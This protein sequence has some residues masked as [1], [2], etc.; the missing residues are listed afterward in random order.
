MSGVRRFSRPSVANLL[1]A[2]VLVGFAA[3]TAAAGSLTPPVAS[4][5]PH[6]ETLHGDAITDD[7]F[8]LRE[9]TNPEVL[10]YLEAEN[11]YAAQ[12]LAPL[13]GLQESLY[14]EMLGRIQQTDLSVPYRQGGAWYYTR[15]EEGKQYPIYCRKKGTLDGKEQVLLDVNELAKGRRYTAVSMVEPSDDGKRIAVAVD[16]TGYRQ[17]WLFV[18]NVETG[19]IL[20]DRFGKIV[21]AVW[22]A[23]NR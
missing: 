9:K 23:D 12:E 15:T 11:A 19:E 10:T 3:A 4:R 1:L 16:T 20:P 14:Q 8:W 13:A 17:Y 7:W 18:K 5:K 21:E 2:Y 22:A 6:V